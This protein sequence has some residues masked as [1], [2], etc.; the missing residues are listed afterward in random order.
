[1]DIY[2]LGVVFYQ[3]LTGELPGG[4]IEPPSS[5]VR[6][7]VRLDEVVLRALERRPELRYQQASVLKTQVETIVGTSENASGT[8]QA[9]PLSQ[10]PR[11]ELA[12]VENWLALIDTG[13]FAASWEMGANR[14]RAGI[15]KA[16]WIG[17]LEG[18]R[19][20]SDKLKSRRL[21][22]VRRFGRWLCVKYDAEY[23]NLKAAVETATFYREHDGQWR[24]MG[25]VVLP[26][27]AEV[28]RMRARGG[29]AMFWS[30][31]GFLTCV[32][33]V[34]FWPHPPQYLWWLSPAAAVFGVGY[35]LATM[36]NRL[37]RGASWLGGLVLGSWLL[38]LGLMVS[39]N[40]RSPVLLSQPEFMA[41]FHAHQIA[42][43]VIEVDPLQSP[44]VSISGTYFQTD[45]SSRP[46]KVEIRFVTQN[47]LLTQDA[48]RELMGSGSVLRMDE[49]HHHWRNFLWGVAP[50]LVL[51]LLLFFLPGMGL[52]LL[53]RMF[54]GKGQT[55][56]WKLAIGVAV[57]VAAGVVFIA[58]IGLLAAVAIPNF[59][60]GRQIA[61]QNVAQQWTQQGWQF[62]Q[63]GKLAE[64][65]AKF[66][67][68]VQLAPGDANAWNGLG[69]AQFNSGNSAAAETAF[70]KALAIATNQPGALNGLGQIY[71]SQRKYDDAEKYLLRAAPQA[72][73]AWYGLARLYLLE[74]KFGQAEKWAQDI[75]N[76]GQGDETAR[77]MLQA[78][79]ATM[80]KNDLRRKIEPRAAFGPVFEKVLASG[81]QCDFLNLD[82]GEVFRHESGPAH[83]RSDEPSPFLDWVHAQGVSLGFA[84]NEAS[85]R[86]EL[87]AFG[88][89]VL[90]F[91]KDSLRDGERPTVGAEA[92]VTNY[93]NDL[94]PAD[95]FIEEFAPIYTNHVFAKWFTRDLLKHPALFQTAAGNIGMLQVISG[96][97]GGVRIRYKLI[98]P[99][100]S[101]GTNYPGDWIWAADS[102]NLDRVPP[103]FLLRPSTLAAGQ[104]PF[105]I[106][107]KDRYLAR[108]R[109][110]EQLITSLW[111]QKDSARKIF[112]ADDLSTNRFDFIA[113]A[114]P[115]WWDRLESEIN[116]RF[117]LLEVMR[118]NQR[119]VTVMVVIMHA[120]ASGT[121]V[122]GT[123]APA[124]GAA[125]PG[126][127]PLSYQW[128]LDPATG[129]PASVGSA[130]MATNGEPAAMAETWS[131]A[132]DE[133]TNLQA[134][135][136]EANDLMDRGH[137]EESLQ[138]H[139]WYFNHEMEFGDAYQKVVRVTSALSD[140]VELGRRYPRAKEALIDFRDRDTRQL[141]EG[142]GFSG[143]FDD[144]AAING[145]LQAQDATYALFKTIREQDPQLAGQCYF[146]LEGLLVAKGEYQFCYD[147]M[148]NPQIRFESMRRG[149]DIQVAHEKRMAETQQRLRQ[150]VQEMNQKN[151]RT[152]APA[153]LPL[154]FSGQMIKNSADFFTGQVRQLI[155]ILVATGHQ[156]DAEKIRD[157]ALAVL[158]DDRLRS[159][160]SDAEETI[161]TK[162]P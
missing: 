36:G 44:L 153:Y 134:I 105:E 137:Y 3:M 93:W 80:L 27:Y 99:A 45:Q 49:N 48:E 84:T 29:N 57:G 161:K 31:V 60:K 148:G 110:L 135:L 113:A 47:F 75:V 63:T 162:K 73:A 143:L 138:R 28:A 116:Q 130:P 147:H 55:G 115:R 109:T 46:T 111:S 66:Q 144:V 12:A 100:V 106:Y 33:A 77:Q 25:L 24:A 101:S 56:G 103:I 61:Q 159:A 39:Q 83:L 4:K 88:M 145:A 129:L 139:I 104:E 78:A 112:F 26:A 6:I 108:G 5:K 51:G 21:R 146:E 50:F 151:G 30:V 37:G 132:P 76:S 90:P 117:E 102:K 94:N 96:D 64:A 11:A 87:L 114:Q 89:G 7:D 35:G 42:R 81:Q 2:A 8:A 10:N 157:Q 20:L 22:Q 97:A 15:S 18:A 72:P 136:N 119:N 152:N 107:G 121:G 95:G 149:Y 41:K 17:R 160:I 52:Y 141:V 126:A 86:V 69:W 140:W 74:G 156:A 155:E 16:E 58:V 131:P 133:R 38:M 158:D 62:L 40:S 70:Q 79:K 71:L 122:A 9:G 14:F 123:N 92:K 85:G 118:M 67:Q 142:K 98:E 23:T 43:G 53:W 68:A 82:T 91:G 13:D 120:A 1:V 125:A 34:F 128:N 19:P 127:A 32:A 54:K 154:D 65:E 150:S 124:F 59:V